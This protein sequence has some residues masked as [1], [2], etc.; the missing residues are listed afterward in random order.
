ML[1]RGGAHFKFWPI[2]GALTRRGRLFEG[3]ANSRIYG[4]PNAVFC[5]ESFGNTVDRFRDGSA[6]ELCCLKACQISK[7]HGRSQE[8]AK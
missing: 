3:G 7:V 2:G 8:I 4:I 1:I 5:E 6:H